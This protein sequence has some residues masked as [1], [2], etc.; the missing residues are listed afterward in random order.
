MTSTERA[1]SAEDLRVLRAKTQTPIYLLAAK[2]PL[3]PSRLSGVLR[4]SVPLTPELAS[5][6]AAAL[7][8][9]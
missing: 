7:E 8:S 3:H 2:I 9:E 5:R 4:G 6:I 1:W